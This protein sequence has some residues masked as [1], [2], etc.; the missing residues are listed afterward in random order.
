MKTKFDKLKSLAV[1]SP[2]SKKKHVLLQSL[3]PQGSPPLPSHRADH[4]GQ[5]DQISQKKS[6]PPGQIGNLLEN[7]IHAL[8]HTLHC[9]KSKTDQ[10]HQRPSVSPETVKTPLLSTNGAG[11]QAKQ[12]DQ[13]TRKPQQTD[14]Q[15]ESVQTQKPP[16]NHTEEKEAHNSTNIDQGD[17]ESLLHSQNHQK[18]IPLNLHPMASSESTREEHDIHTITPE[19]P[20]EGEQS[21]PIQVFLPNDQD[22]S[23]LFPNE[24]DHDQNDLQSHPQTQDYPLRTSPKM[25]KNCSENDTIDLNNNQPNDADDIRRTNS[26]THKKSQWKLHEPE[27][28][29]IEEEEDLFALE[30]RNRCNSLYCGEVQGLALI[31]R[32]EME[33]CT[34][35]RCLAQVDKLPSDKLFSKYYSSRPY[36]KAYTVWLASEGIYRSSSISL[37]QHPGMGRRASTFPQ[38]SRQGSLVPTYEGSRRGSLIPPYENSQR[39]S[40]HDASRRG[41]L[42]HDGTRRSSLVKDLSKFVAIKSGLAHSQSSP[43]TDTRVSSGINLDDIKHLREKYAENNKKKGG[44]FNLFFCCVSKS[45][46]IPETEDAPY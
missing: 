17:Q 4:Q 30:G 35:Y 31:I 20:Q 24:E 39:G 28:D 8:D 22:T 6:V 5:G 40:V 9:V 33:N 29:D 3:S 46:D 42:T 44:L 21:P 13:G 12:A 43:E 7:Q 25:K 10:N 34:R 11:H 1:S 14:K 32:H 23:P 15:Q 36:L 26:R 16:S 41:S 27:L 45:K 18:S 37:R 2:S 19:E 38:G